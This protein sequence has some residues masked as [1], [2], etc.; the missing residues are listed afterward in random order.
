[1]GLKK[2]CPSI[3]VNVLISSGWQVYI[4]TVLW[5]IKCAL[6]REVSSFQG[7]TID[8]YILYDSY[9]HSSCVQYKFPR[10]HLP[11]AV[12]GQRAF[13]WEPKQNT[14]PMSAAGKTSEAW[15]K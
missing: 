13:P 1:M 11:E 6:V 12:A 4:H 7:S 8:S 2:V 14:M 3:L 10:L 9:A 15:K 5:G